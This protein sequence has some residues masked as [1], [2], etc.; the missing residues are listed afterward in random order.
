[1]S[2]IN[3]GIIGHHVSHTLS[4][5]IQTEAIQAHQLPYTYGVLDV[6]AEMLPALL[7]SLN[8][9]NFR[10][11]NV[12]IPYKQA[13]IPLL[14]HLSEEA[15]AIGA[16]NTI[17]NENGKLHGYNTD[18]FGI[19]KSLEPF[20]DELHN[21]TVTVLGA[22]GAARA[23]LYSLTHNFS[24]S[25]IFLYNRS[26]QKAKE[27]TNEF[28]KKIPHVR[29]ALIETEEV[30]RSALKQSLLIVN[31]TSVGMK[32]HTG[33][34]PIPSPY[35]LSNNQII[36]DI[37]YNPVE[38]ELLRHA[39]SVHART[40]NGVEMLVHQGARSFELWTKKPFPIERA[41]T[42]LIEELHK[43]K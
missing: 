37:I 29:F 3:L 1:M 39:A 6:S 38:T 20:A 15:R 4:P 28:Q 19:Q 35:S 2:K 43:Q 33:A 13:V 41:R 11:V 42:A 18:V 30:L 14:D 40:I 26:V 21:T 10:G 23:V 8:A 25:K 9:C 16:V 34:M 17:V 32:P 36:F 31:T 12:T 22:G 27:L 7:R 24:P 5:R